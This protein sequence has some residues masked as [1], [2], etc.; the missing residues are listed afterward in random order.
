MGDERVRSKAEVCYEL[1]LPLLRRVAHSVQ[2][3][4]PPE[5]VQP[6][7]IEY[8]SALLYEVGTEDRGDRRGRR[9]QVD[10][11]LSADVADENFC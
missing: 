1:I 7:H 11:M 5:G 8:A 4:D 10:F 6:G 9:P 3:I 2:V